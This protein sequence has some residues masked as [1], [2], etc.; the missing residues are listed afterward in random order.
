[1][2]TSIAVLVTVTLLIGLRLLPDRPLPPLT[3][4][5]DACD[6]AGTPASDR[7]TG[8]GDDRSAQVRCTIDGDADVLDTMRSRLESLGYEQVV[9]RSQVTDYMGNQDAWLLTATG[10]SRPDVS[11]SGTATS[12]SVDVVVGGFIHVHSD[13]SLHHHD[14]DGN[15]TTPTD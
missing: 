7:W 13:N 4:A 5:L 14:A 6:L 10:G 8:S 9:V 11:A 2:P 15:D 1:M 12:R 3:A